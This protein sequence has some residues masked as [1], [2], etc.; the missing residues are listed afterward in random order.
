MIVRYGRRRRCSKK[1]K[2]HDIHFRRNL[3]SPKQIY[4]LLIRK[5]R[6]SRSW[7]ICN[8][9]M[10]PAMNETMQEILEWGIVHDAF[11]EAAH[12]CYRLWAN[13]GPFSRSGPI[14]KVYREDSERGSIVISTQGRRA[15]KKCPELPAGSITFTLNHPERNGIAYYETNSFVW[16]GRGWAAGPREEF[17]M[18]VGGILSQPKVLDEKEGFARW[19]EG[20]R[21][22][23]QYGR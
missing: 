7:L 13:D 2:T 12:I 14:E 9:K 8:G 18:T 22:P 15:N 23:R 19:V 21:G 3:A 1:A 17:F 11:P 10:N 5:G 20:L 16:N 6:T 4:P